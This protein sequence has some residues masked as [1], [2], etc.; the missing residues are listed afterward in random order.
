ML[1][2]HCS[3]R[4]LAGQ[5]AAPVD[6]ERIGLV[7]FGVGAGLAAVEHV[8]GGVV[9]QRNA[10]GLGFFGKDA[11]SDGIDGK[12]RVRFA[13]GLVDG[14]V[15]RGVDDQ[16]GLERLYPLTNAFRV[17]EVELVT[18]QHMQLGQIA[19]ALLQLQGNLAVLAADED[20]RR[21]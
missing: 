11:R 1:A 17:G 13:F 6:A 19:Q 12:R 20:V 18:T 14:S 8:V 3:N 9:D 10:Q 16:V 7:V 4:L 5:L 21:T 15:G 2:T